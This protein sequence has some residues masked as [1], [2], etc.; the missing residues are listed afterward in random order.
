MQDLI[1]PVTLTNIQEQ[2]VLETFA[3]LNSIFRP[4]RIFFDLKFFDLKL[5]TVQKF[6]LFPH[7]F[8]AHL[9]CQGELML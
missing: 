2:A 6:L 4:P 5:C 8:L 3:F 7:N 9:L 1:C